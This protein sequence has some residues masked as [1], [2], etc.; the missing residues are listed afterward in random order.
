MKTPT[1]Y[2]TITDA[3]SC[4]HGPL[5]GEFEAFTQHMETPA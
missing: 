5:A 3:R 4:Q 2:L 1:R